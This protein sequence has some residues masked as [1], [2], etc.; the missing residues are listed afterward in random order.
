MQPSESSMKL[1]LYLFVGMLL[2][3]STAG[4]FPPALKADNNVCREKN[5][6]IT[7]ITGKWK[8]VDQENV[9]GKDLR[10]L[11]PVDC[12]SCAEG[13]GGVL[14]VLFGD[15]AYPYACDRPTNDSCD[16]SKLDKDFTCIRHIVPPEDPGLI[17]RFFAA[18]VPLFQE[19]PGR[20]ITPVSRGL[21]AELADSVVPLQGDRVDLAPAFQ[22]MDPGAYR[23]RLESLS[24]ST[25]DSIPVQL[26]WSGS[27]PATVPAPG[28]QPGLYRLVRL[29]LSAEPAGADGWILVSGPER[30]AEDSSGFQSAV[31]VTKKWPDDVDAR[32]PRAVL[33]AYLDSVSRGEKNTQGQ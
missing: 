5:G 29:T 4:P 18:V 19:S 2:V 8:I 16:E 7:G 24:A 14:V 13:K 33:R 28:I 20:Y 11:N 10:F 15:K 32:G 30:F 9:V 12:G 26:Q 1:R 27:G 6:T 31:A 17:S 3:L 22:E 25:K 21:E 23:L